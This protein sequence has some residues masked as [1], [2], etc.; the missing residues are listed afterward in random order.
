MQHVFLLLVYLGA[1]DLR[2]MV[3]GDMYFANI[4]DCQY[5]ASRISQ[6]H[7]NYRYRDF[8]DPKDR[9]TAYCVPKYIE[10]GSVEVY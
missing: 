10:K 9:I 1:G 7:G 8:I 4:N 3:S 5:Y 2:K 6:T